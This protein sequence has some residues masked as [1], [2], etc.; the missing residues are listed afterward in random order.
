[1]QMDWKNYCNPV[2]NFFHPI[3]F[4]SNF[5]EAVPYYRTHEYCPAIFQR[6]IHVTL[7]V[8]RSD[9]SQQNFVQFRAFSIICSTPY[10]IL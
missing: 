9:S 5:L 7:P 10:A 2:G 6:S 4:S 1:M 3:I 8:L